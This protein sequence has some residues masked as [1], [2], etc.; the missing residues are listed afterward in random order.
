MPNFY[1]AKGKSVKADDPQRLVWYGVRCTYWTDD[2]NKLKPR[3]PG[4]PTCPHCGSPGMQTEYADWEQS[5]ADYE[6]DRPHPNYA[7][8]LMSYKEQCMPVCELHAKVAAHLAQQQ[9]PALD[10]KTKNEIEQLL[11]SVD[12]RHQ[13][14]LDLV[15]N[16]FDCMGVTTFVKR[17]LGVIAGVT[18]SI[19]DNPSQNPL[20]GMYVALGAANAVKYLKD[21]GKFDK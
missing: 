14:I 4:I 20:I 2:F 9:I 21:Q 8:F 10:Q 17:H 5:A 15:A 13:E 16:A 3:G 18:A 6:R 1:N 19:M 7:A 12:K 11:T